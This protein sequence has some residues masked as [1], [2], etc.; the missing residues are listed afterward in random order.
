[1]SVIYEST[2]Q[3]LQDLSTILV[4]GHVPGIARGKWLFC[5][6]ERDFFHYNGEKLGAESKMGGANTCESVPTEAFLLIFSTALLS[7]PQ[8]LKASRPHEVSRF[9]QV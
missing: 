6:C 3:Y 9:S 1:M 2:K 8:P 4:P 5:S 7:T